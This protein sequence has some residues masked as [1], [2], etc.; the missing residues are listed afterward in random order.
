VIIFLALFGT[1][2]LGLAAGLLWQGGLW[3]GDK[4]L[5]NAMAAQ[6]ATEA[7]IEQQTRN[8]LHAMQ[9]AVRQ[10]RHNGPL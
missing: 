2:I 10:S 8:A 3:I 4:R 7:R 6:I 9:A 1:L 5:L